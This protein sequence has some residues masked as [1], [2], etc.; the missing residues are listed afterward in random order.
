MR[1]TF[2]TATVAAGAA[3]PPPP[4]ASTAAKPIEGEAL[5]TV[6]LMPRTRR[7]IVTTTLAA[8]V[9]AA[10]T[11]CGAE[12]PP[13]PK[14]GSASAAPVANTTTALPPSK[15]TGM[16]IDAAGVDAKKMVDLKVDAATGE[17]GVPN[18][19]TDANS[20]GWWT[21]GV[22]PGEKGVSVLVAHFDTRH[23]PA[24]MKDVKKIKP[25]D[26][27]E[28]P[29]EDGKTAKFKIRE[30]ED[31]NKKDFPTG[32]VYGDTQ[33][34]ELRLLTCGGEIKDGHRTNNIIFYAD[35]TL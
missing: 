28:V 4:P 8:S 31:V 3:P 2:R 1:A 21:E 10:L 18:A 9:T 25:G 33:R 24:L 26:L 27:I 12:L 13:D 7:V 19:D 23:G 32:K 30:I 6:N 15:P 20:P 29:R 14:V 35:L 5:R 17:L 22:T 34:P 11:A 16:K